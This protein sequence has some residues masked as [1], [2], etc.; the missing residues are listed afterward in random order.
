MPMHFVAF[1]NLENF[2]APE[3]H[4]GREPWIARHL[5]NELEGWTEELFEKKLQQI[6]FTINR[7]NNSAGP[8]ILGICEVENTFVTERLVAC[9]NG[10][11]PERNYMAIHADSTRDRRA[12]DTAFLY[13]SAKYSVDPDMVFS[14][15]VMRRTGTRDIS[16]V[17][18][19]TLGG[20]ELVAMCNHWPS[21]SGGVWE[22]RGYR[23]TAGE[24]LSYWHQRIRE[25]KENSVAVIAMG[26]FND[27]PFDDSLRLYA[28]ANRERGDVVRSQSAASFYNLAWNYLEQECIDHRGRSRP[29]YGTLYHRGNG[30]VFDQLLVSKGLLMNRSPLKVL[31]DTARMETVPEMVDHRSSYGPVRFGLPKG[32]LE[33]NVNTAGF[34]DHFPVSVVIYEE[35]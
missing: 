5:A 12:I 9:L 19:S 1:W 34:S 29:V 25:E 24:T 21:R 3:D 20:R 26:D 27:E 15:F 7:M 35:G 6:C 17:T 30:Y 33:H 32:N 23:M 4:E 28:R 18:F 10:L 8:D 16:Q 22:S 31:E 2:F 13:D 14:Y 11:M